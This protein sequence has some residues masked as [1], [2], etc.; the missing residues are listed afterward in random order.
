MR[1]ETSGRGAFQLRS[2]CPRMPRQVGQDRLVDGGRRRKIPGALIRG[3][4]LVVG[5]HVMRQLYVVDSWGRRELWRQDR[6]VAPARARLARP[7]AGARARRRSWLFPQPFASQPDGGRET[8]YPERQRRIRHR[9]VTG[10]CP[11]LCG[12][13]ELHLRGGASS[14]DDVDLDLDWATPFQ[15]ALAESA[16]AIPWGEVVSYGELAAP[17]APRCCTCGGGVSAGNR[18]AL[19]DPMSPGRRGGRHRRLRASGVSL[20]RR[21]LGSRGWLCDGELARRG[22]AGRARRRSP[23]ARRCDRLAEASALFHTAGSLHLPGRGGSACTSSLAAS[24]IARRGFALLAE[25]R[26]HAE[27]RTYTRH[28][29]DRGTRISST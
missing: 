11:D 5:V 17:Q 2:V 18:F 1:S 13:F 23:Q 22:R 19:V 4:C 12:R 20:K 21:L 27:I 24:A 14:Y 8:P 26:V 25:L 9:S 7:R 16:R 15:A 28:A 29:F 3:D 6:V 10:W